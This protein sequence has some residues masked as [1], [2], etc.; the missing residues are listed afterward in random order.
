M[1]YFGDMMTNKNNYPQ[2]FVDFI[3]KQSD[4]YDKG[5]ADYSVTQL[6][7]APRI[8]ILKNRYS[9]EKDIDSMI[10][11]ALGTYVHKAVEQKLD[12]VYMKVCNSVVGGLADRIDGK[13]LT[14]FK[15]TRVF[16]YMD[17]D[18]MLKFRQQLLLY[19]YM[20]NRNKY[21][22]SVVQNAFLFTDWMPSVARRDRRYPQTRFLE[23]EWPF[24]DE[25][26]S[27]VPE[28]ME[29]RVKAL[30]WNA[31]Q[32]DEDLTLCTKKDMWYTGDVWAVKKKG[33]KKAVSGGLHNTEE[34]AKKHVNKL[35]VDQTYDYNTKIQERNK[36]TIEYREGVRVRCEQNHCGVAQHCDDWKAYCNARS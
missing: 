27:V 30:E 21:D 33:A 34:S 12:R 31:E 6:L 10:P 9:E 18:Q 1:D 28:F 19:A 22:I 14:D 25:E 4:D 24:S 29:K 23:H 8:V 20:Y 13:V 26:L 7:D 36:Y 17:Q 5:Q 11:S 35:L 32:C 3:T 15:H 2:W 16:A